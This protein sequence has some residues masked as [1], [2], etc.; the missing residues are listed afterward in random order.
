MQSPT[1]KEYEKIIEELNSHE[2]MTTTERTVEEEVEI[3]A[4]LFDSAV[5]TNWY[6]TTPTSIGEAKVSSDPKEYLKEYVRQTL[7]AER[8]KREGE[9][10][11]AYNDGAKTCTFTKQREDEIREEERQK[12]E[13]VV[14]KRIITEMNSHIPMKVAKKSNAYGE[15]LSSGWYAAK[16]FIRQLTQPN[17]QK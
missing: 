16:E 11:Q 7:Q 3:F 6:E 12:R 4:N 15:G 5:R 9:V 13:E 17:N 10:T 14:G 8:Q 1:Q 2:P